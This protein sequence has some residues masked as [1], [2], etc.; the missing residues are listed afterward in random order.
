VLR[1]VKMRA[2]LFYHRLRETLQ[3]N[4]KA[5]LFNTLSLIENC[6]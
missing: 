6:Q 5:V 4:G 2:E 3:N 1:A